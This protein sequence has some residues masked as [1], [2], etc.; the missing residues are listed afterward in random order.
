MIVNHTLDLDHL[1]W[2]NEQEG[3]DSNKG[4]KFS[5]GWIQLLLKYHNKLIT[6]VE[7]LSK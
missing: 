5:A 3:I 2:I 4:S 1:I 7:P 6:S